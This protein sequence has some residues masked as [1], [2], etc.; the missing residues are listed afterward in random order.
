[1][2]DS[3]YFAMEAAF[4]L[5]YRCAEKGLNAQAAKEYFNKVMKGKETNANRPKQI[6]SET[7]AK[8]GS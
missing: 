6:T 3:Y 1:M 2:L 5:G 7:T 8:N 4:E